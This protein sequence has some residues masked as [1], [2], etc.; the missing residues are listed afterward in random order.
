MEKFQCDEKECIL[1]FS[2]V[3]HRFFRVFDPLAMT[4]ADVCLEAMAASQ[5]S[6]L[7]SEWLLIS[8]QWRRGRL[9]L[10]QVN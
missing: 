7:D 1:R 10:L 2:Q 5:W 3:D 9:N 4:L 6:F 8:P